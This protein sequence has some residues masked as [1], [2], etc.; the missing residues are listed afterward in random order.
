MIF[1]TVGTQIGFDRLIKEIDSIAENNTNL[2]FF[3][4]I[5]DGNYT[6]KNFGHARFLKHEDFSSYFDAAEIII[7]HAGMGTI[8]NSRLKN[9]KVVILPRIAALGEHRNDHQLSTAERLSTLSGVYI[10]QNESDLANIIDRC[11]GV[12]VGLSNNV[13]DLAVNELFC[14]N[15]SNYVHE[16]FGF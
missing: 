2:E 12:E 6:P 13:M 15:I 4:Q 7:S 14:E 3:A 11:L 5:A 10:S 8:I 1:V 9:K 16:K